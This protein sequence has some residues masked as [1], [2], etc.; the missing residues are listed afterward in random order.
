MSYRNDAAMREQIVRTILANCRISLKLRDKA[1]NSPAQD[2]Q[3]RV[4]SGHP[5]HDLAGGDRHET[6]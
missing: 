6:A 4:V 3:N 1:D 2:V 5:S